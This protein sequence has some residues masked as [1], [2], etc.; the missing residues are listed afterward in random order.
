M[1]LTQAGY[2]NK[3]LS[4]FVIKKFKLVSRPLA[5]HFK[6]SKLQEPTINI[7]IE[8]MK[9]IPYFNVICIIVYTMICYSIFIRNPSK[10]H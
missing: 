1:F 9:K 10:E 4:K 3:V 6:L 2:V 5:A 8:Y 7:D